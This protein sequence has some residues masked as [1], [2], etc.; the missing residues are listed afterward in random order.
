M[1]ESI[2]IKG[3]VS[4]YQHKGEFTEDK[5][6]KENTIIKDQP[7]KFVLAGLKHLAT[8]FGIGEY[9]NGRRNYSTR[10]WK[11]V[12]GTDS[13]TST[14]AGDT[15]LVS[16][17]GTGD[18][19]TPNSL[20]YSTITEIS[21]GKFEVKITGTWFSGTVSGTVGE[22]GLYLY[23]GEPT[24]FGF[25]DEGNYSTS[26]NMTNRLSVANNEFSSFTIDET[27]SLTIEWR[28]IYEFA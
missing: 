2:N 27:K 19:T 15:S 1:N 12:I 18:G 10:D 28:F 16:P 17:I 26:S 20:N 11:M 4:V 8:Y 21:T 3:L 23:S 6:T 25:G 14:S 22:I 7:N 24:S 5:K 9:G 13:S